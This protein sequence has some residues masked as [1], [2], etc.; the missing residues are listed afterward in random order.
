MEPWVQLI[1]GLGVGGFAVYVLWK[2]GER[3]VDGQNRLAEKRHAGLEA[4][5]TQTVGTL[6]EIV[7]TLREL[8]REIRD[9]RER[10]RQRHAAVMTR[11][12][13]KQGGGGG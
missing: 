10:Q 11:L 5:Q 12:E 9:N 2:L 4:T 13:A 6:G 1:L 3:Y 7:L 8:R